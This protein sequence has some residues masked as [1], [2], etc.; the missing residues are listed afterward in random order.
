[1][2]V[3]W[4]LLEQWSHQGNHTSHHLLPLDF[5]CTVLTQCFSVWLDSYTS[6]LWPGKDYT[7]IELLSFQQES[8]TVT[9]DIFWTKMQNGLQE[10]TF[11]LSN[12]QIAGFAYYNNIKEEN[13]WPKLIETNLKKMVDIHKAL[14]CIYIHS[15]TE[16]TNQVRFL[17]DVKGYMKYFLYWTADL[18]SRLSIK[19]IMIT[20]THWSPDFF[21]LLYTTA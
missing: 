1:M 20:E 9:L 12:C 17:I 13:S 21:R 8:W 15:I 4:S 5:Q 10:H 6:E 18:K 19:A 3:L 11:W 7:Y 2:L 16:K 14:T